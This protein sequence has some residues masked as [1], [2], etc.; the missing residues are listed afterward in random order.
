VIRSLVHTSLQFRFLVVTLAIVLTV[1]GMV[2]LR[3]MPADVLPEFAPPFVEVQTEALGLSAAEVESLV[4][5][6]LE[7]LLQGVPWLQT[8]RSQSVP[9]M[10]SIILVFQPG[11]DVLRARQVVQERLVLARHIPNVSRPPVLLQPLSATSRVMIIGL[12]S[13]SLS[14]IQMGV[15]ARWKI[16]PALT[17]V[18]GVA[19]VSIWGQRER[20][21]QVRVDPE[22]LRAYGLSLDDIISS[23]GNALWVSPLS[24]LSASTPGTG[25]WFDTPQQRLEVRHVLPISTPQQLA[26]VAIEGTSLRL[27]DIADVVEDHQP[28]I[29]EAIGE[30][31]PTLLLV[32]EKFPGSNTLEVTR[33]LE[34]TLNTLR[35]GLVGVEMDT[36]IFRPASFIEMVGASLS[37]TLLISA[38]LVAL[39]LLVLLRWR[40][41]L[42]SLVAVPLSLTAAALVLE[43]RGATLNAMTLAGLLMALGIIVDDAVVDADNLARRLSGPPEADRSAASIVVGA[44]VEMRRPLFFATLIGLLTVAPIFAL[45]GVTGRLFQPLAVSYA[46][47]LLASMLVAL[48]VTPALSLIFLSVRPARSEPRLVSV[49]RRGYDSL[50]AATVRTRFPAYLTVVVLVGA[51]F[52][53]L[54]FLG[55]QSLLPSFQEPQ[56]LIAWEGAPGIS[57]PE[58]TRITAQVSRELRATPG[59]TKVGAHIGRAVLGDEVVGIN[60]A[61]IWVS[62]AP[63]ANYE[64]TLATIQQ[65]VDR[66]PGLVGT[67]QSYTQKTLAQVLTGSNEAL[68][69]RIF[70]PEWGTLRSTAQDVRAALSRVDG[71]ADVRTELPV[72]GPHIEIEVDLAKA[73]RYGINPGDVRRAASTL[74]NGLEVGSL[75][76]QQKVFEVIVWSAPESRSSVTSLR[77][78]LIDTP[79]GGRV[80]LED[81]ADVRVAPTL[82]LI[83]REA[84]SRK[85]DV[86][87]R[88]EGRD[89]GSVARDVELALKGVSFPLE[90]HPK[91]LGEYAES[92]AAEQRLLVAGVI[93]AI[94]AFLLLQAA[95]QSWRLATLALFTLPWAVVGGLLAAALAGGGTLSLGSLVGLLTVLGIATRNGIMLISHF[96]HLENE[97]GQP[98]GPGLVVRGAR[99]RLAPIL[100]TALAT[101]VAL[102]PLA[103]AGHTPGHEI[104]QPMAI[105]ILGGLVTSSM[106][107]LVVLPVLYLRF[108][109]PAVAAVSPRPR[110]A[111]VPVA[112]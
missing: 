21:L 74:V 81:V 5:L 71:V 61:K 47:A 57:H 90:Y 45:Q 85:T 16:R 49:L 26:Q 63:T 98:I 55:M 46:L 29:G 94:G 89:L 66:Y 112:S 103:L 28:L 1:T 91:I 31:G 43:W 3:D 97:E 17:G 70:G 77:E 41:A 32:V 8:I 105:V 38:A 50:L 88:V 99:E 96:Q 110:P 82:D 54:P 25:G 87:L 76:D 59:V 72:E 15:L 56:L 52:L 24:F 30:A 19:N 44:L 40:G 100:M 4:T 11:T 2:R 107:S 18:P 42:I 80:R 58:M 53:A 36:T 23:T 78:L 12:T 51:G 6:N 79:G 20:Q 102:L 39:V 106:V 109:A 64:S 68:V 111:P 7:E 104:L 60:A 84:V 67:V 27:G 69:V 92:Q 14:A 86:T 48:I 95:F 75:F 108:G 35:P 101:G 33:G 65:V 73:K 10:S 13:K 62:I 37:T 34:A 22:W 93:A 9:G 83:S